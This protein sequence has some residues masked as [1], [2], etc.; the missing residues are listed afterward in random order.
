MDE[1]Y[2][3]EEMLTELGVDLSGEDKTAMLAHLN[4]TLEERIGAE[5]TES[6]DDDQLKELLDIQESGSDEALSQ[7]LE[8]HVPDLQAIVQD[9]LAILLGELAENAD[10]VNEAS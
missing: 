9:N 5:I 1:Q 8:Q 6:L 10:D 2:I 4:D 7:W 3:T